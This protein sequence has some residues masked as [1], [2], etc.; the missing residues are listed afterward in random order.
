MTQ[1]F[2]FHP[3]QSWL[4][5]LASTYAIL[6][7]PFPRRAQIS[8]H[9]MQPSA[10]FGVSCVLG[11]GSPQQCHAWQLSSGL[12][13]PL[14]VLEKKGKITKSKTKLDE[15]WTSIRL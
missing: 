6:I 11:V 15:S 12:P 8:V 3:A 2:S 13:A 10:A 1:M 7:F 9:L 14:C 4:A 5:S